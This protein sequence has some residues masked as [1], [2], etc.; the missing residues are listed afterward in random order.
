VGKRTET[1]SAMVASAAQLL[2]ERGVGGTSV[3]KVLQ[4][5]G[6]PRG[7]VGHHFPSG[8]TELISDAVQYAGATVTQVLE[9]AL[10]GKTPAAEVFAA[11]CA[12]YRAQLVRTD[13][14]AGCPVGAVAQE[15]YGDDVLR[16][17][18]RA[19]LDEWTDTLT[20]IL[21]NSGHEPAAATE[22]AHLS[23]AAIEGAVLTARIHRSTAPL[24]AAERHLTKL[25]A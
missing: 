13:F 8:K 20:R 16:P 2:R 18:V 1:R 6:G 17:V 23:V 7:S 14:R 4:H 19:V 11:I 3:A 21:I 25:L 22:L 12:Y 15:A 10:A 9:K 24:D 5:S